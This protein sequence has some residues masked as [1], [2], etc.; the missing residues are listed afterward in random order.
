MGLHEPLKGVH[1]YWNSHVSDIN[2]NLVHNVPM[3]NT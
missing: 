2:I 1:H 3:D